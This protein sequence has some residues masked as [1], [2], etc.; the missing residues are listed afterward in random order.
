[1]PDFSEE[2]EEK[3]RKKEIILGGCCIPMDKTS[4]HCRTCKNDFYQASKQHRLSTT[5]VQLI[6]ENYLSSQQVITVTKIDQIARVECQLLNGTHEL[7]L[8][9]KVI[10]SNKLEKFLSDFYRCYILDWKHRYI[11]K[12]VLDGA[13]WQMIITF[14]DG[15]SLKRYGVNAY[16]PHWKKILHVFNDISTG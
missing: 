15:T 16:P 4:Y 14:D 2:L 10:D 5:K 12:F 6:M 9:S 13:G 8:S 3:I 1:M 11:D 7:S